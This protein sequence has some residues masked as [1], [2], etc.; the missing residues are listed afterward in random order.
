MKHCIISVFLLCIIHTTKN[1]EIEYFT[2][3]S[4]S[5]PLLGA[6]P[7]DESYTN[8]VFSCSLYD[9][10]KQFFSAKPKYESCTNGIST[11]SSCLSQLS[12]EISKQIIDKFLVLEIEPLKTIKELDEAIKPIIRKL[13]VLEIGAIKMIKAIDEESDHM[14]FLK[15][16]LRV[17]K[18]CPLTIGNKT[19]QFSDLD[20]LLSAEK[21]DQ[22]ELFLLGH[23]N[24]Y[25]SF[26]T[27]FNNQIFKQGL[28]FYRKCPCQC[29]IN[30][31][32]HGVKAISI[33]QKQPAHI[34][35][36]L[37][38]KVA[39]YNAGHCICCMGTIAM[40]LFAPPFFYLLK[41]V[42]D[43]IPLLIMGPLPATY[44]LVVPG[45]YIAKRISLMPCCDS[46]LT[47]Y[48]VDED[49]FIE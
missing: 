21:K 23:P 41:N 36:N 12:P 44:C 25:Y 10:L 22:D 38:I 46:C 45:G 34:Q 42:S 16:I 31:D 15:Q 39:N 1:M 5:T 43:L 14:Q 48:S 37:M 8:C 2:K 32:V 47:K 7:R 13:F 3:G 6:E 26:L 30:H 18:A 17:K 35:K 49:K 33:L 40:S 20:Y 4:S 28:Y 9:S 27:G 11:T 24:E 29:A 19:Y